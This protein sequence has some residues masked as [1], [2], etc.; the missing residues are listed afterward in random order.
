MTF[1]FFGASL[2]AHE[3]KPRAFLLF[4]RQEPSEL[5][6]DWVE[7]LGLAFSRDAE[8]V[9]ELERLTYT[10]Q[11]KEVRELG[12]EVFLLRTK[13]DFGRE[14]NEDCQPILL[15]TFKKE[16]ESCIENI[17]G[18]VYTPGP[19]GFILEVDVDSNGVVL[20]V[21]ALGNPPLEPVTSCV[22]RVLEKSLFRP[23]VRGGR[24][25]PGKAVFTLNLCPH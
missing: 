25:V 13:K 21:T 15:P 23:A 4:E 6:T 10:G 1:M 14:C 20:R 9:A 2:A 22:V 3:D 16:M 19:F 11:L 8:S 18:I 24:W 5:P 17:K 12:N 7:L